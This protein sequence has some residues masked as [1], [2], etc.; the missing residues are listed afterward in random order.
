M[1]KSKW[2]ASRILPH[3]YKGWTNEMKEP[4]CFE[5]SCS[6]DSKRI[7][8]KRIRRWPFITF[9]PWLDW[10]RHHSLHVWSA[11]G[12]SKRRPSCE[13]AARGSVKKYNSQLASVTTTASE[14]LSWLWTL[15]IPARRCWLFKA[16]MIIW[17]CPWLE[18]FSS[19]ARKLTRLQD[20]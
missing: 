13:V 9:R 4:H 12:S 7:N 3:F 18:V 15:D 2:R 11:V 8:P 17:C 16:T 6:G 10:S 14:P 5:L 1:L 20:M 19:Y